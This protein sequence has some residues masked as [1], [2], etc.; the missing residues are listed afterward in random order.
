[1]N[2][3]GY[4]G[5]GGGLFAA[6]GLG[7]QTIPPAPSPVVTGQT[8]TAMTLSQPVRT[9]M[10]VAGTASVGAL[11][12]HGYRRNNSI[13]W[14]L[15]WGIIGGAFWPL[16]IPISLAQGFGVRHTQRNSRRRRRRSR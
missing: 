8:S 3:M 15:V 7:Q 6:A 1:M 16:A 12:Y 4:Y 10:L 2:G 5:A 11:A 13:G 9:L 14:A